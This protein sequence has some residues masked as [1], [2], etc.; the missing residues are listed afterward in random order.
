MVDKNNNVIDVDPIESNKKATAD[1]DK[2]PLRGWAFL[3]F[4]LPYCRKGHSQDVELDNWYANQGLLNLIAWCVG[5]LVSGS[6]FF[7]FPFWGFIIQ[8]FNLLILSNAFYVVISYYQG[9]RVKML[10][11]G[12]IKL[13]K[14]KVADPA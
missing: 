12:D 7:S 8:I 1:T 13:I 5:G 2:D 6:V 14:S 4:F 3:V 10:V 11:Y 9:K